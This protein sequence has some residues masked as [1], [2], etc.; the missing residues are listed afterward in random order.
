MTGFRII[1][2]FLSKLALLA[3]DIYQ[4]MKTLKNQSCPLELDYQ[5]ILIFIETTHSQ[6]LQLKKLDIRKEIEKF[7][8]N[9]RY[10]SGK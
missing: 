10:V 1:P 2:S 7:H 5:N 6:Q 4:T 3:A 8:Q 9:R